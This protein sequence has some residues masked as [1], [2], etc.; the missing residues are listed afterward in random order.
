MWFCSQGGVCLS[1]YWDTPPPG[2]DTPR[3]RAC[4][5]IRSTRGL[6]ASY[7][8]AILFCVCVF[9]INTTLKLMLM[10]T[11]TQTWS[12]NK[13]FKST[14]LKLESYEEPKIYVCI[15]WE[16]EVRLAAV[17]QINSI[18]TQVSVGQLNYLV[19][20]LARL[21]RLAPPECFSA[22]AVPCYTCYLVLVVWRQHQ[23]LSDGN[24][25]LV[26]PSIELGFV[27]LKPLGFHSI[28]I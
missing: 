1:A 6:Y 3:C 11:Q 2:A 18:F 23:D 24:T 19:A 4:W 17:R 16:P 15:R 5:E 8:N 25:L 10:L 12:V 7:W 28:K 26:V 13:A 21:V 22:V 27:M 20:W 9:V 14:E